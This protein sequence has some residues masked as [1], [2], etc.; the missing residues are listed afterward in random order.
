MVS[1]T[2]STTVVQKATY[3]PLN[4]VQTGG[5]IGRAAL[6]FGYIRQLNLQPGEV[7]AVRNILPGAT[8]AARGQGLADANFWSILQQF[9][10]TPLVSQ[11][12][13]PS[14]FANFAEAD[15]IAFGNGLTTVRKQAVLRL[16][17]ETAAPPAASPGGA[18]QTPTGSRALSVA[19]NYLNTSSVATNA[20]T[21]NTSTSNMGMLNLE[22][23]EMTPDGVERG[24]LLATISLAPK[25]RTAVVQQEWSVTSQEFTSIVTDSLEN[26]SQTGVTENTQLA[27]STTSQV[28]HSNQFNVTS[29]VQGGI[30]L[31]SGSV[32]ASFG[33]QDQSSQ[34]ANDSR[35]H[36]IQTTRQAS[37]RVR[38]S[39][40]V[41]ISTS[42]V[43][44]ASQTS[45][46]MFENPSATD[47]MRVDYFSLM[48]KWYVALY[49]Y[50]LRLTYD[51]TI[52]EPG[53]TLRE[54]YAQLAELQTQASGA[55]SFNLQYADITPDDAT[56][57]R[58]SQ[59]YGVQLPTPPAPTQLLTIGGTQVQGIDPNHLDTV[60]FWPLTVN[61]PDGYEIT[62]ILLTGD[63]DGG[64]Y[65]MDVIGWSFVSGREI[66]DSQDGEFPNVT[67]T[68]F[69]QGATG[70]QTITS[71]FRSASTALVTYFVTCAPTDATMEQW[72][73]NVWGAC[74]NA[75][76]TAFY[77]NQQLVNARI[78]RSKTRLRM[79]TL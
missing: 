45:T 60:V 30:K 9:E 27:Q 42:T 76:Q 7:D 79:W 77:A 22:R 26:Y 62:N 20:F 4:I 51:I 69:L 54:I 59:Q 73:S 71:R 8:S 35:Q 41:T 3:V 29:S 63:L 68:G 72:K 40:K 56:V 39:H 15:L 28:A 78:R 11:L 55:F 10:G 25:E 65:L 38:Q 6:K 17:Q 57:E 70:S 46:R 74:Y 18:A 44:G 23:L 48:R 1:L 52:P 58:L 67:L 49:R 21:A 43:T 37:S 2:N 32:S 16:Q 36:A 66:T 14:I 75:A 47:P 33:G 34:S 61:V 53:G 50:G 19:Q 24:A 12:P 31:I 13:S 64:G 5:Y